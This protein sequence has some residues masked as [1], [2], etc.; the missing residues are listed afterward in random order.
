MDDRAPDPFEDVEQD[1]ENESISEAT[2]ERRRRLWWVVS[3]LCG[4]L[5]A[6]AAA[7]LMVDLWPRSSQPMAFVWSFTLLAPVLSVAG[8]W[9]FAVHP[10]QISEKLKAEYPSLEGEDLEDEDEDADPED[11]SPDTGIA[12][13]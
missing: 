5:L 6:A 1:E 3:C 11:E 9:I 2:E 7:G 10:D 8:H 4:T 12:N 13:D